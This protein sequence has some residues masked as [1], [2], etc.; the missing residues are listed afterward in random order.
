MPDAAAV[1]AGLARTKNRV[2]QERGMQ[3]FRNATRAFEVH[4]STRLSLRRRGEAKTK[5][6]RSTL[7]HKTNSR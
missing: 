1:A 3:F 4:L 6:A 5:R 2:G 7:G